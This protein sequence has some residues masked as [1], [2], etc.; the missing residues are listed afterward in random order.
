MTAQLISIGNELLIGDTVNTNASWLGQFLTELGFEVTHVH[1]IS[2]ELELIKN[3]LS[4]A[5]EKA[6]VVITTGGLGPTHDDM[7]KKA[8]AGLFGA[9]MVR[10]DKVLKH[11]QSIFKKRNLPFSE[12]NYEQ[13][14]VPDNCEVLFNNSGTAPGMW[15]D[16]G[17]KYLAVLPGVPFEMK[18]LMKN[19]IYPKLRD[20]FGDIGYLTSRYI[21]TAGVGESTLSDLFLNDAGRF[22]KNGVSLAFLPRPGSVTLRIS[23]SGSTREE[24]EH[25]AQELADYI[26]RKA[27]DFV[28]GEG[29]ELELAEAVGRELSERKLSLAAA[30]SCTGGLI[31]DKLTD[32]P[33][34]SAY[35]KGAIISYSNDAKIEL[36]DVPTADIEQYGAVSKQV[37]LQ[38]AK[39]VARKMKSDIGISATGIAGP[40]GGTPEKPVG[41]VWMGFWSD[42]WHFALQALFT[43]DRL[44]NKLRTAMVVLEALRR[45][46][47][48]IETMPYELKKHLS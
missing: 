14:L 25:H 20:A 42:E 38:M 2:D 47:K 9:K 1:T 15:F 41:T 16:R 27:G 43:K 37:A 44:N 17:N 35:M 5:L 22:F 11:V 6:D 39:G 3:T 8:V 12:S 32:I 28:F 33:G 10:D 29:K 45:S 26:Y 13:A 7:T 21:K 34:S 46:L 24:A 48:G 19:R 31:S 18:Y 40:G 4:E 30:E 36:L 23:S